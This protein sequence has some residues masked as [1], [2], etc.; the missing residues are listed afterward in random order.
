MM[1]C[2]DEYLDMRLATD[3]IKPPTLSRSSR[4]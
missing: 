3:P 2:V 4:S 1:K